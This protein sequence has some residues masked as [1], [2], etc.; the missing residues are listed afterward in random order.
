M[1]VQQPPMM[2]MPPQAQQPPIQQ[3]DEF[4]SSNRS[5][6]SSLRHSRAH[7]SS[8]GSGFSK[9]KVKSSNNVFESPMGKSARSYTSRSSSKT[10]KTNFQRSRS[11]E[12]FSR[13]YVDSTSESKFK[14]PIRRLR[15]RDDNDLG[16]NFKYN[17][18]HSYHKRSR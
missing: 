5:S 17:G 2:I 12:D 11:D 6:R 9:S 16:L 7:S 1:I 8:V 4:Y 13:Y 14:N 10:R 3:Q 15:S 18:K